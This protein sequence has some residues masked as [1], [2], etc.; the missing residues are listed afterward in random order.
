MVPPIRTYDQGEK[1]RV[2]K[3]L[4]CILDSRKQPAV[5]HLNMGRSWGYSRHALVF[6]TRQLYS[7]RAAF[8]DP[9]GILE[10][11]DDE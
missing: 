5:K 1:G 4:S 10:G 3:A 7:P 8:F 9:E 2:L 6:L 11:D